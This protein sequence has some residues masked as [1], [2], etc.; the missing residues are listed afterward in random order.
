MTHASQANPARTA[1]HQAIVIDMHNDLASRV[2]DD[3]YDPDVRHAPGY[4]ADRGDS[5]LPRLV[6]SGVT[7][8]FLAAFVDAS[9]TTRTPDHSLAHALAQLDLVDAFIARHPDHLLPGRTG[10]DIRRAKAQHQIAIFSAVE[11]GHAIQNSLDNLRLLY[12]RGARYLTLTWNNGND[13]AG[14]SIGVHGTRTGGLTAFG[15][16]VVREMNALGMLVD[17]SHVS[18]AT[19]ADVIATSTAPVIASHSNCRALAPHPRNLS[20]NMLRAVARTGGVVNVNFFA[21]FLDAGFAARLDR[22]MSEFTPTH[23]PGFD[24]TRATRFQEIPRPPLSTL[25][26]HVEHIVRVAGIEHVGLGSD[27][28]GVNGMLPAGIADITSL[29]QLAE[30]LFQRGFHDAELQAILG[31]NMLRV[32]EQVLGVDAPEPSNITRAR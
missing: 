11:G 12:R 9:H 23:T 7:A 32:I 13:W 16:A 3:G 27:F 6:E 8:Q 29:P 21:A 5:D 20:D 15:Q 18:D 24:A 4:A 1:Y 14:S 2:L 25:V 31:G 19:F 26:D 10:H 17:V 22:M 30:A 28:D